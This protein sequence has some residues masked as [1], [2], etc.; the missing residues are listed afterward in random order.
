MKHL[1]GQLTGALKCLG[2]DLV[3]GVTFLVPVGHL[4]EV[5]NEME[6]GKVG[7]GHQRDVVIND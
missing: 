1:K 7:P 4:V 3:E 6:D 2:R 5:T